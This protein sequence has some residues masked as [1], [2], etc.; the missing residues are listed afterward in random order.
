ML[1]Q[2]ILWCFSYS[3]RNMFAVEQEYGQQRCFFCVCTSLYFNRETQA[4]LSSA[5]GVDATDAGQTDHTSDST[6]YW[7]R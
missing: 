2:N 5:A 6:D 7:S 1:Q 3:S 4:W